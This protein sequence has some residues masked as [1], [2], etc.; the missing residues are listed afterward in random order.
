MKRSIDQGNGGRWRAKY[1]RP[2][3]STW[4]MS[5][6]RGFST[7]AL[8]T[9]ARDDFEEALVRNPVERAVAE[10]RRKI[11]EHAAEQGRVAKKTRQEWTWLLVFGMGTAAIIG[12]ILARF[13][14]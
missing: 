8:A 9:K 11:M 4:F 3:D 1:S 13:S 7:E 14:L 5:P 2:D 12:Y 6:A 10:G